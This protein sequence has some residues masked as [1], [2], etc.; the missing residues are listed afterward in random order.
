MIQ[1]LKTFSALSELFDRADVTKDGSISITEYVAICE[2]HGVEIDDTDR[3]AFQSYADE[4]GEVK[5]SHKSDF[6]VPIEA[7]HPL[8]GFIIKRGKPQI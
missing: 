1:S 5:D 3:E 7:T 4:S 6:T 8:F 2:E